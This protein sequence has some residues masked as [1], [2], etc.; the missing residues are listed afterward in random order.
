MNRFLA[1]LTLIN[2]LLAA[3]CGESV[4]G[5]DA[6]GQAIMTKTPTKQPGE[7]ST[8]T[9]MGTWTTIIDGT[10][11]DRL[12]EPGKPIAGATISYIVLHSYFA[13]LQEGRPNK[14]TTGELGKFA[15]PVIV[16]DTDTIQ[17]LIEARGYESYQ[18]R[19]VGVDLLAGK[20]VDIGLT[21]ILT[22]T[23]SPP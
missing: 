2:L 11:V 8:P 6:P 7:Q 15:L 10:I 20:T 12:A 4:P 13:E 23:T 5:Q 14:T 1:I 17:I 19:L 22:V 9:P 3:C 18:E 16:H 21:P